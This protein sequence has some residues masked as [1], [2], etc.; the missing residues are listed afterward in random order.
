VSMVELP[1]GGGHF[2]MDV[3]SPN[4]PLRSVVSMLNPSLLARWY[5]Q[6]DSTNILLYMPKFGFN[7][8]IGNLDT[9]LIQLGMGIA[10]GGDANFTNL[11]P[12][13]AAISRVAHKKMSGAVLFI[14]MLDDP[15]SQ[16]S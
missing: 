14:G 13:A 7:Y 4:M 15:S 1:Y 5:G 8:G 3:L 11:F 9:A 16:G 12:Q 2:V 10:F 6:M